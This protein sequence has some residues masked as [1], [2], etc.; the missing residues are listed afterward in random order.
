MLA[1]F[2]FW[3][4]PGTSQRTHDAIITSL[5]RQNDVMT[6]FWRNNDVIIASYVRWDIIRRT[7]RLW[8][9]RKHGIMPIT[10]R[11]GG[12]SGCFSHKSALEILTAV[13]KGGLVRSVVYY[14]LRC[15][16]EPSGDRRLSVGEVNGPRKLRTTRGVGSTRAFLTMETKTYFHYI[17]LDDFIIIIIPHYR[18][19]PKGIHRSPVNSHYKESVKLSCGVFFVLNLNRLL[20]KLSSCNGAACD[21]IVMF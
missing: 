3:P 14:A 16:P 13:P 11:Y 19:F 10:N 8:T 15:R 4:G 20:N 7:Q 6:S 9:T 18:S 1:S 12:N 17:F 2:R 5:W 21:A